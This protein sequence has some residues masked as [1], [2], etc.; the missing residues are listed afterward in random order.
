MRLLLDPKLT[1]QSPTYFIADI[2][3]NH[4]GSLNR[5]LELIRLCAE[6]GANA[7]KFQNFKAETIVS[8]KGFADLGA[9]L[10]HQASWDKDVFQVYKEAELPLEW[11]EDLIAECE[12]NRIDYF[13]APYDLDYID[14]FADKMSYFKIGSGDITWRESIERIALHGKPILLATGASN[15]EEVKRTVSLIESANIPYVLMQCNTNY[16]GQEDN[17]DYL[18]LLALEEFKREFP[19]AVLGLSD[20]SR[21][22]VAVIGAVALGARVVE[23]HFT[24]DTTRN[25]PDHAFSL[26]PEKWKRMVNDTRILER[27]LGT[28]I[29]KVEPNEIDARVVQRRCLRFASD[30]D[31]GHTLTRNDLVSL[32]PAPMDSVDPFQIEK[33]IGLKILVAVT[34]HEALTKDLF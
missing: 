20:H 15:L 32:R 31:A 21:G 29:K 14:Y 10:T 8:S 16:T 23:K 33:F 9:K 25:G 12:K 7:A 5:A 30:L 13:T 18:N 24:D 22:H 1:V 26:D 28:G 34:K 17:F 6:A 4:D 2:A 19:K 11:T 27:T 3:A